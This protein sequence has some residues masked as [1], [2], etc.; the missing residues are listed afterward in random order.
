MKKSLKT[1]NLTIEN[2]FLSLQTGMILAVITGFLYISYL[3]MSKPETIKNSKT[4]SSEIV[5]KTS[6]IGPR[7]DG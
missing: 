6:P 2:L 5:I 1:N 7:I 4:E 3:G